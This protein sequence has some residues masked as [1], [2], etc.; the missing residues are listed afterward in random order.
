MTVLVPLVSVPVLLF[1][2]Y[3]YYAAG[4]TRRKAEA[5]HLSLK[6][7]YAGGILAIL[8]RPSHARL[9]GRISPQHR[10]D[11][12]RLYLRKELPKL[13]R[14]AQR[15]TLAARRWSALWHFAL[16]CLAYAYVRA[17][18]LLWAE[19]EDLR[20]VLGAEASLL[21]AARTAG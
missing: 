5:L 14:E 1:V 19:V 17:K 12:S 11:F 7:T 16:F 9:M 21:K 6:D 10:R 4:L 8:E 15:F 2:F 20:F 18:L 13:F 3:L